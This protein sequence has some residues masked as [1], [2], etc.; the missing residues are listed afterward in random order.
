ILDLDEV[1]EHLAIIGGGYIGLEYAQMF[2]RFG[3]KVTIL[4]RGKTLMPY[5]DE[6]VCMAMSEIFEE[7]GIDVI[8]DAKVL[9]CKQNKSTKTV[10][11][12]TK[13][14]KREL[15]CSHILI[16]AGRRPNIEN[17]NLKAAGIRTQKSGTI[18][19]NKYLQTNKKHIYAL[20]DV[21]G[22][23]AFTHIAY[24]DY[25]IV[26][27]NLLEGKKLNTMNRVIPYCL[28]TDPQLGRVGITEKQAKQKGLDYKVAKIPMKN[29]ARAIETAE[30]RGFMKAIIHAKTKKILGAAILGEEGGEIMSVLQMAMLGNITYEQIRYNIFAHPLYSESLMNLFMRVDK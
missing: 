19:V 23:A 29:V 22:N 1:P 3:A 8:V 16:S 11:Y 21:N 9:Y 7:D 20:G 6:D 18:P 15:R 24:N 12:E 13:G 25:V 10:A 26:S 14:E 2:R 28:F 27:K 17:L 30:T 5:E 4:E